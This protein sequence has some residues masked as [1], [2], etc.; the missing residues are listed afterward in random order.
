[1]ENTKAR[2]PPSLSSVG[3]DYEYKT[4]CKKYGEPITCGDRFASIRFEYCCQKF[5]RRMFKQ[6]IELAADPVQGIR[7][8]RSWPT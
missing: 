1:M 2:F 7:H 4:F 8:G 6:M 5:P 3:R